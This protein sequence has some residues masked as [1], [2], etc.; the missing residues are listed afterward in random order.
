MPIDP[1]CQ[2]TVDEGTDLR[3]E[4]DGRTYYFCSPYCV[5]EFKRDPARFAKSAAPADA[6]QPNN[7]KPSVA[8][9]PVCGMTVDPNTAA[10]KYDYNGQTYIFCSLHCLEK[11]KAEPEK[12][13]SSRQEESPHPALSQRERVS[14][15]ADG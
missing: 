13:L 8:I 6:R 11:F 10:G 14:L 7:Q 3:A 4:H 15:A 1:I 2:M 9:D 5:E 12:Y